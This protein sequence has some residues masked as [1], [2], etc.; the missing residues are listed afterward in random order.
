MAISVDWV[1][2]DLDQATFVD[3]LKP[4]RNAPHKTPAAA[5]IL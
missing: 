4:L 2:G 5:A 3:I 1:R